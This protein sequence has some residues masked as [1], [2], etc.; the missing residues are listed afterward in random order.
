MDVSQLTFEQKN[1]IL[2]DFILNSSQLLELSP[3]LKD[4][5]IF[6]VLRINDYEIRHSNILAW[7]L[8]PYGS[9]GIGNLFVRLFVERV[10][11]NNPDSGYSTLDWAFLD[12][13]NVDVFREKHWADTEKRD[14]LDILMEIES[15]AK[16][17]LIAIENKVNSKES[18]DQTLKYREHIEAEYKKSIN[19]MYVYLTPSGDVAQDSTWSTLSYTDIIDLLDSTLKYTD[20]NPEVKMIISDYRKVVSQMLSAPDAALLIKVKEIYRKNKAAID[21]INLYKPDFQMDVADYISDKL[22]DAGEEEYKQAL[23][24]GKEKGNIAYEVYPPDSYGIITTK[25]NIRFCTRRMNNFIKPLSENI[26]CWNTASNYYYQV[27]FLEKDG[28]IT[29]YFNIVL[30]VRNVDRNS[31]VYKNGTKLMELCNYKGKTSEKKHFR[32]GFESIKS[33]PV[34]TDMEEYE[35]QPIIDEFVKKMLQKINDL[36]SKINL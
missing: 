5:N 32:T 31:D 34:D 9:H 14:S 7:L 36:E 28:Q 12:Y 6:D 16:E 35:W 13:N 4:V 23:A 10:I 33:K 2:D 24:E 22:R 29:C 20:P 17:Y 25:Y 26:S 18:K 27:Y 30:N 8:D 11:R 3:F 1:K 15:Q 21:L 19:K